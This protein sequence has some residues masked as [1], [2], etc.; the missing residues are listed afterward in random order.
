MT[1]SYELT[2]DEL[3]VELCD[4]DRHFLCRDNETEDLEYYDGVQLEDVRR[5]ADRAVAKYQTYKMAG[6]Y[7][8]LQDELNTLKR[9]QVDTGEFII[10]ADM[11]A[12][13]NDPNY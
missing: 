8:P 9:L 11:E 1:E 3:K 10:D 7:T 13:A 2:D 6:Q 5:I 4:C 12:M